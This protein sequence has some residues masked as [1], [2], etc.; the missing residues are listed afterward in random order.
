MNTSRRTASPVRLS[1]AASLGGDVDGAWWM[2]TASM[3]R[4]LPDLVQALRTPLGDVVDIDV[5]WSAESSAPVL[6]TLSVEMAAKIHGDTVR[7][8]LM[9]VTGSTAAAKILLVPSSTPTA[10]ALMVLRHAARLP[11]NDVDQHTPEYLAAQRAVRAARA[12]SFRWLQ[13][14]GG[15]SPEPG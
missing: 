9:M 13:A 8:R 1:L 10:L 15:G 11:M 7:N 3:A 2:R 6:S 14:R 4:E 12:E 5:N